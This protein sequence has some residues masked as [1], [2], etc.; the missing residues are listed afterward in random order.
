MKFYNCD[1][2]TQRYD[3]G[4]DDDDGGGGDGEQPGNEGSPLPRYQRR[5]EG[6]Q[7]AYPYQTRPLHRPPR[8][9]VRQF[10]QRLPS[11]LEPLPLL[12][13]GASLWPVLKIF[14]PKLKLDR[15]S[16]AGSVIQATGTVEFE[17][18]LRM[19]VL[20]GGCWDP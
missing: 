5:N 16:V 11:F 4:N 9:V 10:P 12:L 17:D 19:G 3:S 14:V 7:P 8:A 18:G 15:E 1:H 6:Q 13:R 20:P 2:T